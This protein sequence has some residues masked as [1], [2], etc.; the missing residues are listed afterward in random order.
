MR[1]RKGVAQLVREGRPD[2]V[3]VHNRPDLALYLRRRFPSLPVVL[4]LHN[5][6]CRMRRARR[7]AERQHL[8]RAVA[9]VAVSE[10]VRQRFVSQGVRGCVSVL[11]N[12]LDLAALPPAPPCQRP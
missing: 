8:A 1:Y 11:P 6:P 9:V 12:S 7:P 3:E 2:L 10:W 4:I 5:D